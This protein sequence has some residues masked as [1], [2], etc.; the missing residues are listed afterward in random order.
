MAALRTFLLPTQTW[1]PRDQS[2]EWIDYVDVSAV[3]SETLEIQNPARIAASDAPSR[4]RKIVL[5]GDTLFATIRPSLKRVAWVLQELSGQIAST[6]FCVLRANPDKLDPSYLFFLTSSDRFV[7]AVAELQSGAS[8]PA[9][10]DRDVMDQEVDLPSV[11]EQRQVAEVLRTVR[12]AVLCELAQLKLTE[13]VKTQAMARLFTRGLRGEPQKMSEI[14][15]VPASWLEETLDRRHSV[16]S[17]GTPSRARPEYWTGGTI[18]WVK[19][20]EINYN[21]ITETQEAITPEALRDSAARE[22]DP[23]TLM[24]AMYGQGVTRGKVAMLGI[25][26]ACNQACAAVRATSPGVSSSFL[27]HFLAYRYD[28]IRALA[29]GGQQQN[30]SLEIVKKL[31]IV[32]PSESSEQDAISDILDAIDRKVDLHRRKHVYLDKLFISLLN[33]LMIGDLRV[34]DFNLDALTAV[35]Q[36]AGA[37]S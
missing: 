24:M 26:A 28:A 12:A 29:H 31:P 1:N 32:L 6:A 36:R 3:S 27:F 25:A 22:L 13:R 18:P 11:Q 9:V 30:L 33:R 17:G 37:P 21:V 14:G 16:V 20:S 19:S 10:R 34:T 7:E 15:P 2:R 35:A 4:A 5:A 23:G 8:Y